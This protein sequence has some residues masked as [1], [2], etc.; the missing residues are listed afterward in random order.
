MNGV[1]TKLGSG[2][3]ALYGF[4]LDELMNSTSRYINKNQ[5]E[6]IPVSVK[7]DKTG[8]N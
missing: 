3:P 6:F 8:Y 1:V 2:N 7:V 5:S 4:D